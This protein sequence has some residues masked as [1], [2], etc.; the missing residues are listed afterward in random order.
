MG[1]PGPLV[2]WVPGPSGAPGRSGP[3]VQLGAPGPSG[4]PGVPGRS[5]LN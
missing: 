4:S 3:L 1:T 5:E 2:L